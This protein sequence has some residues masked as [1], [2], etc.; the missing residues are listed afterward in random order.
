MGII[1]SAIRVYWEYLHRQ[2]TNDEG[3][4]REQGQRPSLDAETV[5]DE[6]SQR[7]AKGHESKTH[8]SPEYRHRLPPEPFGIPATTRKSKRCRP[9]VAALASFEP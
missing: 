3:L 4:G 2:V 8:P 7:P 1:T 9:L 5:G 6:P